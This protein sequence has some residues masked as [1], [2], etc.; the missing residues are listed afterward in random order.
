MASSQ[1]DGLVLEDFLIDKAEIPT[2]LRKAAAAGDGAL[3]DRVESQ[4]DPRLSGGVERWRPAEGILPRGV[5]T[6]V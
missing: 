3:R 1:I 2:F 4:I 6:F 5:Y